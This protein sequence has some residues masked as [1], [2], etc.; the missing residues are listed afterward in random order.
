MGVP[1]PPI[2]YCATVFYATSDVVRRLVDLL[3]VGVNRL[4]RVSAVVVHIIAVDVLL[5]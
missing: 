4:T 2:F 3:D 1:P 5:L